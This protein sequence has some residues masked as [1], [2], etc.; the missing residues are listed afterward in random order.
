MEQAGIY[1]RP[2]YDSINDAGTKILNRDFPNV[3]MNQRVPWIM[4]FIQGFQKKEVPAEFAN[5]EF[6]AS[7]YSN[8]RTHAPIGAG[9]PIRFGFSQQLPSRLE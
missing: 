2:N 4:G 9:R 8:G 5:N 1:D 3:P 7:G 6:Y